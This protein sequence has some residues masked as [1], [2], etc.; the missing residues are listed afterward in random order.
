M[1]SNYKYA[2][3]MVYV[4]NQN[5]EKRYYEYNFYDDGVLI[6][7]III[8]KLKNTYLYVCLDLSKIYS[9]KKIMT[10]DDLYENKFEL[11]IIGITF[12]MIMY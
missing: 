9:T 3:Q 4:I 11:N 2:K 7:S 1:T 6:K 5:N 8:L 12:M 10:A